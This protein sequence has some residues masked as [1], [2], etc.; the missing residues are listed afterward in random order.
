MTAWVDIKGISE[1]SDRERKM[2]YNFT[3]LQNLT[4]PP[5]KKERKKTERE[6]NGNSFI[7]N[8]KQTYVFVT[9]QWVGTWVK[10]FKRYKYKLPER[11]YII[12]GDEYTA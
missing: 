10:G 2:L 6:R 11:K 3:Q 1:M 4:P 12:H 9:G 5:K 8:I 7:D